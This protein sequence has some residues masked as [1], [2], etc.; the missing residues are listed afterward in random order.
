M[1]AARSGTGDVRLEYR[2]ARGKS[3]DFIDDFKIVDHP[4]YVGASSLDLRLPS[5]HAEGDYVTSSIATTGSQLTLPR[6]FRS[7][8]RP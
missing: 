5:T 1:L 2:G 3:N 4:A 7:G 6:A 8:D